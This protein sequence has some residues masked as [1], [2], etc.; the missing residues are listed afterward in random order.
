MRGAKD[1]LSSLLLSSSTCLFY[2]F[3]FTYGVMYN[4][5]LG[6]QKALLR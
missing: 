1:K 3:E 6:I 5:D 2:M 4:A